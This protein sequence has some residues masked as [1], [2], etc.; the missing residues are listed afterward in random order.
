LTNTTATL[1]P[2]AIS[3]INLS[4]VSLS[5]STQPPPWKYITTGSISLFPSGLT[6]LIETCPLG[7]AGMSRSSMSAGSFATSVACKFERTLRASSGE[8]SYIGVPPCL[9]TFFTKAL[10]IG[11]NDSMV[12][13]ISNP[14][15][16]AFILN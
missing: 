1:A 5:P 12:W 9:F 14:P 16:L 10:V 11:S 15:Q 8:S 6:I 7:P 3:R 13:F 2:L 4:C